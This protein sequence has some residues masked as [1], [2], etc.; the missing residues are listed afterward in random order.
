MPYFTVS[1]HNNKA[2]KV[3]EGIKGLAIEGYFYIIIM[4]HSSLKHQFIIV[5]LT[6]F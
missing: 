2:A 1:V 6:L 5:L 4:V 3:I